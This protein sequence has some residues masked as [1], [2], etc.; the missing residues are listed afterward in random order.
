MAL[1]FLIGNSAVVAHPGGDW[2]DIS[3]GASQKFPWDEANDTIYSF[4]SGSTWGSGWKDAVMDADERWNDALGAPLFIANSSEEPFLGL[5]CEN[6]P[7]GQEFIRRGHNE[8]NAKAKTEVCVSSTGVYGRWF[9]TF[10]VDF[11]WYTG[12]GDAPAGELHLRGA[13]VHE[14]GHAT[15][16]TLNRTPGH[17]Q[18]SDVAC[19]S[20]AV[21][22]ATMCT[23]WGGNYQSVMHHAAS[24]EPHDTHTFKNVY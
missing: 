20:L 23:D 13:A 11:T 6:E 8:G 24:L 7:L 3:G 10:D 17:F 16:F 14:F 2:Y 9:T 21:D 4:S 5:N 12:T 1:V 19:P 15:G 18:E 22:R